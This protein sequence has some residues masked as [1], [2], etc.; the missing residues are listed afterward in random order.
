[1]RSEVPARVGAGGRRLLPHIVRDRR[2]EI[3]KSF[4]ASVLFWFAQVRKKETDVN[5]KNESPKEIGPVSL[6]ATGGKKW[7]RKRWQDEKTGDD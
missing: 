7:E 2:S 6:F 3:P 5:K 4:Y 1:M